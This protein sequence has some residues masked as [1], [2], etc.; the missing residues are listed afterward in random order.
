M[1]GSRELK[2]LSIRQRRRVE[3]AVDEAENVTGLQL[4]IY[5][6]S[7][8]GE[9]DLRSHAEDVR[10]ELPEVPPE[11]VLV[12]PTH[13]GTAASLAL[14][15][16]IIRRRSPGAVWASLHSDAFVDDD[17]IT[18]VGNTQIDRFVAAPVP[19]DT[20]SGIMPATSAI[21]VIRIGRSRSRF[22]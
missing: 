9:I 12:E 5:L 20:T 6:G 11:Q 8:E 3:R 18:A 22:A 10:R 17:R 21:V 13:R 15:A 4:C 1:A 14:P 19:C 16:L 7:V 2:P